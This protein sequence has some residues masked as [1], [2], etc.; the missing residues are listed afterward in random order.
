[1][2]MHYNNDNEALLS[3]PSIL[4]AL[5]PG[6]LRDLCRCISA[7]FSLIF[8]TACIS[9]NPI[10]TASVQGPT[11]YN[12][13]TPLAGVH[14]PPQ[15]QTC[16]L[17]LLMLLLLN[18]HYRAAEIQTPLGGRAPSRRFE[19]RWQWSYSVIPLKIVGFH[20]VSDTNNETKGWKEARTP[21]HSSHSPA[22]N[23]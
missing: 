20:L 5:L 11:V 23:A 14:S 17:H 1:M 22:F 13:A 15:K 4:S 8:S 16:N 21:W 6:F 9:G 10:Q 2:N 19:P 18:R 3:S 7:A 12:V